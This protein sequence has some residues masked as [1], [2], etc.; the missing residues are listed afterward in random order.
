MIKRHELLRRIAAMVDSSSLRTTLGEN[1]GTIN[2]ASLKKAT[3]GWKRVARAKR[4]SSQGFKFIT[5]SR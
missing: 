1:L 3:K 4:L 2:A 5:T